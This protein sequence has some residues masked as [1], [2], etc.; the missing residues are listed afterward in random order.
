MQAHGRATRTVA[1]RYAH[2]QSVASEIKNALNQEF[3]V[4]GW[5][6][7]AA[8]LRRAVGLGLTERDADPVVALHVDAHLRGPEGSA[9]GPLTGDAFE[10]S[11][12]PKPE[13]AAADGRQAV[14][15][16]Q[17]RVDEPDPALAESGLDGDSEGF[18]FDSTAHEAVTLT[19]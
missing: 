17:L 8:L 12:S 14:A 9:P 10:Q 16:L 2:K 3:V 13:E 5:D 11:E 4:V 19:E 7:E 1:I 15:E 18:S 6:P